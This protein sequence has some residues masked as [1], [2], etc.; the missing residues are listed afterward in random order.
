MNL[1]K[2]FWEVD[3]LRG[4]AILMMVLFHVISDLFHFANFR[5]IIYSGF[6]RV[7]AH[8]T[9]TIFIFLVGV[10]LSLSFE[11]SQLLKKINFTKYLKRGLKI[12]MWGLLITLMT[13]LFY[14]SQV[15]VFGVLHLIG[16]AIILAYP[17]LKLK[18]WNL[19]IG[20][21]LVLIGIYLYN[22]K[23]NF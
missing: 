2:R 16:I 18:Y 17:F 11:R 21:V 8:V 3:F 13:W 19:G 1:K 10:S 9:A 6:W 14:Q 22:L 20:S 12:F 7:F 4:I 23:F 5:F 15:V